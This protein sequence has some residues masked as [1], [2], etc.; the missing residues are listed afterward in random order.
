MSEK[1]DDLHRAATS[2]HLSVVG[3]VG[4]PGGFFFFF[5]F[6]SF[7]SSL[8]FLL[9][10]Q[11]ARDVWPSASAVCQSLVFEK[12]RSIQIPKGQEEIRERRERARV[13]EMSPVTQRSRAASKQIGALTPAAGAL[14]VEVG[15]DVV[16]CRCA[17][18]VGET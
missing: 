13:K 7:I 14:L 10:L 5:F 1:W 3:Y 9:F 17:D 16:G 15:V 4:R 2:C 6:P 12:W 8:Y 11:L 18:P